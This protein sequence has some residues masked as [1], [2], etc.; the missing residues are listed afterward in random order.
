M[1]KELVTVML[2]R[3]VELLPDQVLETRRIQYCI[4]PRV[5]FEYL[6]HELGHHSTIVVR[7]RESLHIIELF[8]LPVDVVIAKLIDWQ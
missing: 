5:V 6:S 2:H 8:E 3:W 4:L 1:N 7:I